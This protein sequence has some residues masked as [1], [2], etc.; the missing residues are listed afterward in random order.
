MRAYGSYDEVE[1]LLRLNPAN[2]K[3]RLVGTMAHELRHA[4]QFQKGIQLDALL[5]TPKTY[6]QNQAVIEADASTTATAVCYELALQGNDKPLESLREKDP[7][8]VNPFQNA[9]AQGGLANGDAHRAAFKG[10]FTDYSTRDAYDSLY[11]RMYEQRQRKASSAEQ[12]RSL[13]R[14]VPVEGMAATVCSLP[15]GKPYMPEKETKDF[16][17]DPDRSTVS[18]SSFNAT[19]MYLFRRFRLDY[20]LEAEGNMKKFGLT[21]R[22]A[23]GYMPRPVVP[24]P[25]P[26][27]TVEN[28]QAA[29]AEKIAAARADR[30]AKQP[31]PAA[32]LNKKKE[33]TGGR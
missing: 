20:K 21:M 27:P 22:P 23:F 4:E 15:D 12:D 6:L 24:E 26:L 18:Y 3:D 32:L 14:E 28:R 8:I 31:S 25:L 7:H 11:V 19:Y 33:I 9:A 17:A 10:W 2:S 16:F 5:D 30:A 29:A 13:L 1:N